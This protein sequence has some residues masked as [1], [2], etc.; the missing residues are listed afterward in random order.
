M[1]HLFCKLFL[2]FFFVY[3]LNIKCVDEV[4]NNKSKRLIDIY[5]AAVK[6]LI[7]NEEL[8]DL[9]EKHNVDYS[10]IESLE[11]IPDLKD[12]NINDDIDDVLS[13][14]IKRKEVKVG[15]LKNKNWGLI[16]NYEINPPIGFWPDVMYIIW[17]AISKHI[18]NDE[19]AITVKYNYYD[20]VFVALNNK[21]IH[22]TDNYFL[23][24]SRLVD[25]SGNNLNKLISGLPIINHSNKI[26]ILKEYNI[27]NLEQLK[28][29]I[30]KNEGLKIGCL[31][32]ANCNALKNIFLDKVT[33]D[34]KSFS[35]Y[36]DLTKSV[37]SK[38]HFIGVISGIPFNFN[39]QKIIVFDSFLK[40]GHSAYF[41]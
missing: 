3:I 29:Y 9:L 12:I 21:N 4:V 8:I 1:M 26:M 6:E 18:F 35:S 36:I 28:S 33:Y 2:F 10:V 41:K 34:Y 25:Q 27:N 38:N 22:M 23:F 14:I 30:S 37:L 31:T 7:E 32:E 15:A 24:N 17:E 5:H 39:E 40:T 19:D 20:N 16:G 11:N 13:E